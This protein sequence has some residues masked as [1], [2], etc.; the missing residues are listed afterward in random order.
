MQIELTDIE[1]EYLQAF[2]PS[3]IQIVQGTF[4]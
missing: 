3:I 2:I 4:R 1:A